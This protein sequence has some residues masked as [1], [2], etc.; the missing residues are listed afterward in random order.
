MYKMM[1]CHFIKV[2]NIVQF[3]NNAILVCIRDFFAITYW[4]EKS[5]FEIWNPLSVFPVIDIEWLNIWPVRTS[6][7][8]PG[9]KLMFNIEAGNTPQVKKNLG[10]HDIHTT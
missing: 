3:S 6:T 10:S 9:T 8:E 7:E 1:F 5:Y 4:R 2:K